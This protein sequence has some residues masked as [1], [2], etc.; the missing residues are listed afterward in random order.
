MRLHHLRVQ[1]LQAFAAAAEVD[2]D[3]LS[4][5]GLF[6]LHG[7]TGAGKTTLLDAVCFALYGKL[8]GARGGD[9]RERA[10]LAGADVPTEVVLELTLRGERLR[11]TRSPRQERPKQRGT[12]TTM[13]APTV[14]LEAIAPDGG[15]RALANRVEEVQ[16]ELDRLLGMNRDQFCQVVL[17]PQGQFARFLH[18]RSDEREELL[19]RL[20]GTER[21]EEAERW[22]ADRRRQADEAL[23]GAL[24]TLRDLASRVGQVLDAEPPDGW[25]DQ[26]PLLAAWADDAQ[27]L[28]DADRAVAEEVCTD[29]AA[30]RSGADAALQAVRV[31]LERRVRHARA[32]RELDDF[33]AGSEARAAD[34]VRLERARSAAAVA[35][36]LRVAATTAETANTADEVAAGACGAV[37]GCD[38]EPPALRAQA[39][40]ARTAA[41][42]AGGLA[43]VE[44]QVAARATALAAAGREQIGLRD[45]VS[46]ADTWLAAAV[47][48]RAEAQAMVEAGRL[49]LAR[50]EEHADAA[51]AA[52]AR[53]EAATRR[54]AAQDRREAALRA[55]V[56]A[57][58]AEREQVDR[59]LAL[60]E[61]RLEGMAAELAATLDDDVPC[62]VCGS[63]EHPEP[64]AHLVRGRVTAA[65]E[66]AAKAVVDAAREASRVA[67][68][69]V[70]DIDALLAAAVAVAGEASLLDLTVQAD[71]AAAQSAATDQAAS[72][73]ATADR[74]LGELTA[75]QAG[76]EHERRTAAE[77]CAA[78]EARVAELEATQ[79]DETTR[80]RAALDG[81]ETV[82]GRV[83]ALEARAAAFDA[84][85]AAVEQAAV[86]R[87]EALNAQARA[88][89]AAVEAGFDGPDDAAGAVL[90]PRAMTALE[91]G[92]RAHHDGLAERRAL[93]GD[94]EL[95]AAV[96]APDPDEPAAMA[97]ARAAAAADAEAGHALE[98]VRGRAE[99]L[100]A[101]RREL[102]R[103]LESHG[104]AAEE[105][106]TV[107]AV[108]TLVDGTSSQNRKR[109]R[110]RAY[111]L[112]AR[113]E[114]I[115]AA[116]SVRLERMTDGR[117]TLVL[118]DERASHGRRSGLGLRVVDGWSGRDRQ[119]ASLSGGETFQASLALALGLADVVAAEAG[120]ARLETLFVDEG[121][122]SL[123]ER[124]LDN[125]LEVLDRLREGGRA[126]GVVSHVAE[127]R[128]RITAQVHV[129]KDREGSR[130]QQTV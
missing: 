110:L 84:A 92:I 90:D 68:R 74:A 59:W 40:G 99:G 122:G 61:A 46:G 7:E 109:M 47:A 85:A 130:V 35:P 37:G 30:A 39:A 16:H 28:A 106:A 112:A 103:C 55:V 98:R 22:L 93:L 121:F 11:I 96:T 81:A 49:A 69:A 116:A 32:A 1:A 129:I 50:R 66:D 51:A 48:R 97:A 34:A 31:Q 52:V 77:A 89:A 38:R 4:D 21:F 80:L 43:T 104:P 82:V 54:D 123:D 79:A 75:E 78:L 83:H 25:E 9:A 20:F 118:D 14:L 86:A 18:A 95:V 119:P 5:A 29:A 8:P 87:E 108:A 115:A 58:D 114:E 70:A 62:P 107:R 126:V 41:G 6:L 124:A 88:V 17:L 113:L 3:T 53:V 64:A 13:V 94:P 117:Y 57:K 33:E 63:V 60:R 45:R 65:E 42:E 56:T 26:P 15:A 71:W 36:L 10:D 125:A 100:R 24:Q 120:G 44:R 67:E 128:Q 23:R 111:V 76:V 72:G 91:A 127:L 102:Q 101:L 12:G 73:A 105:A 2:F 27:V 19:A